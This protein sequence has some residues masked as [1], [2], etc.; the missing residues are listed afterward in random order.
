MGTT[1]KN[2]LVHF[3][4]NEAL[5]LRF[6]DQIES[7]LR[8]GRR[9]LTPF[10]DETQQEILRKVAGNRVTLSFSGGYENAE[11]KRALIGETDDFE[12]VQ[13]RAKLSSYER[14]THSD[15]MGALY[16]CGCKND[17]FGDILVNEKEVVVFVCQSIAEYVK[18]NC[19]QIKRSRVSF[20]EDEHIVEKKVNIEKFHKIVT[21]LRLDSLVS[22]CTNL[23]RAKAQNLVRAKYVK[24]NHICLEDC[25]Y[26]CNNGSILSIRGYGR[27]LFEGVVKET[28][29]QK[30]VVSLGKYK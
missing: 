14:I 15:C 9:I 1:N 7:H 12:I 28:K 29:N 20:H 21:T 6:D 26:L 2:W 27:F 3:K 25:A 5:A 16:N 30:Y 13:L 4:G 18:D 17:H 22:A 8:T 11:R 19:T 10:L 23:S 24:V